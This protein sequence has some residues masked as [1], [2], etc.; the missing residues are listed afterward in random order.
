MN[1]FKIGEIIFQ[2]GDAVY[3]EDSIEHISSENVEFPVYI[4]HLDKE[5]L[6]WYVI[7]HNTIDKLYFDDNDYSWNLNKM[8][9]FTGDLE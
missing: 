2:E 6:S 9:K 7:E 3:W 1:Q 8:K 4:L 5:C